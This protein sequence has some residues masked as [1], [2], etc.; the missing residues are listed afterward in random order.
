MS[1]EALLAYCRSLEIDANGNHNNKDSFYWPEAFDSK[2]WKNSFSMSSDQ[3]CTQFLVQGNVI[4]NASAA[5]FRRD[6]ALKCLNI[7]QIL[8]NFLFTGDWLFWLHYLTNNDGTVCYVPKAQS[9]FRSHSTTTRALSSDKARAS[10]HIRE[11]CQ[12]ITMIRGYRPEQR[13]WTWRHRMLFSG[14]DWIFVEYIQRIK[15]STF[16][17]LIGNGLHGPLRF[18]FPSRLVLSKQVRSHAF[19]RLSSLI[20]STCLT[21]RIGQANAIGIIKRLFA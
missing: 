14:W 13:L 9:W 2:L 10:R 18:Q 11:F 17:L 4:P 6:H 20:Y 16:E 3:F 5:I 15:P 19:P 1:H 7:Q 12:I 8:D 21:W